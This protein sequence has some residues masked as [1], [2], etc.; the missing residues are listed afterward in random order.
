MLCLFAPIALRTLLIRIDLHQLHKAC[1]V[2]RLWPPRV[3]HPY[4]CCDTDA[5]HAP[6]RAQGVSVTV[7]GTTLLRVGIDRTAEYLGEEA[8]EA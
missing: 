5:V 4:A 1:F 2:V 7:V 3:R 6:V 8:G